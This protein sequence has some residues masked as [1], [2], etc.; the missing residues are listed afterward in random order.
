MPVSITGYNCAKGL[1]PMPWSSKYQGSGRCA[2]QQTKASAVTVL[3]IRGEK[4]PKSDIKQHTLIT[5]AAFV[6]AWVLC[7]HKGLG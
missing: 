5:V 7:R 2:V 1:L 4:T 3:S 6:V